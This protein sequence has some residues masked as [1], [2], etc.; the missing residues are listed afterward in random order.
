MKRIIFISWFVLALV[1]LS[2]SVLAQ[3]TYI[4][5][6]DFVPFHEV[7]KSR[8]I[9]NATRLSIDEALDILN[10]KYKGTVLSRKKTQLSVEY[11]SKDGLLI[12]ILS[13]RYAQPNEYMRD[14]YLAIVK[15]NL[16]SGYEAKG[17]PYHSAP[18]Y[19]VIKNLK[20]FKVLITYAKTFMNKKFFIVDNEGNYFIGG[21]ICAKST[22]KKD[23]DMAE[24][25]VDTLVESITFK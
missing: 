16:E 4:R 13:R 3:Q 12:N 22:E 10:N 2:H 24:A 6:K 11:F 8:V 9:D 17:E 21:T 18:Y 1:P 7:A 25:F 23:I 20:D 19:S 15:K 14:Q 5:G